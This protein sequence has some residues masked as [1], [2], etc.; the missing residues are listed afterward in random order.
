ML[1]HKQGAQWAAIKNVGIFP[2]KMWEFN[3]ALN[4]M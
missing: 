3:I 2:L 4:H 1:N